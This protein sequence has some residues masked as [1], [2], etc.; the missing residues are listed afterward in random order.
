MTGKIKINAGILIMSHHVPPHRHKAVHFSAAFLHLHL[1]AHPFW[2]PQWVNLSPFF[3]WMAYTHGA[4]Q[5]L[6]PAVSTLIHSSLDML[7]KGC[8]CWRN[9]IHVP[10]LLCQQLL[11]CWSMFTTFEMRSYSSMVN[12]S[13]EATW[14]SFTSTG[15][16]DR[17]RKVAVTSSNAFHVSHADFFDQVWN[18]ET[19]SH[20]V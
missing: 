14:S 7:Y 12:H 9:S 2:Q 5:H 6:A 17:A 20:L 8:S 1:P 15:P 13:S 16:V 4:F 11:T 19:V 3:S 18:D 10:A